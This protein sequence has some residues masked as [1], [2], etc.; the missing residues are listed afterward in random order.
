MFG[1]FEAP[2]TPACWQA[3]CP[4]P[5]RG[6]E[7]LLWKPTQN[8]LPLDGEGL[9]CGVCV[10]TPQGK[11]GVKFYGKITS[12]TGGSFFSCPKTTLSILG[13]FL[14]KIFCAIAFPLTTSIWNIHLIEKGNHL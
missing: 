4:S 8:P 14:S 6:E 11:V 10:T 9:P 2:L 5:A 1:P 7:D 13:G 3:P 12:A